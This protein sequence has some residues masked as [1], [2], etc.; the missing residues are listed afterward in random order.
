MKWDIDSALDIIAVVAIALLV[1]VTLYGIVLLI[2]KALKHFRSLK[3]GKVDL[4]QGAASQQGGCIDYSAVH[5]PILQRLTEILDGL[6]PLVQGIN[7]M[8]KAQNQALDVLLG[9]AEGDEVNGQVKNARKALTRAEGYKEA[10]EEVSV[11]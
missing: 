4:E 6:A 10:T 11:G 5:T 9:L 2:T 3:V 7:E 8:Q 1:C